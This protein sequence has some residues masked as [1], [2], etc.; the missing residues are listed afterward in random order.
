[1]RLS[2]AKELFYKLSNEL[3]PDKTKTDTD[4]TFVEMKQEYDDLLAIE[5]RWTDI[6]EFTRIKYQ[7][8]EVIKEKPVIDP[9]GIAQVMDAFGL[10]I[11]LIKQG[12]KFMKKIN[13]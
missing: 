13:K 3:H 9:Q 11:D 12:R 7:Y 1:M 8:C 10:G 6:K 4:D 2:E 5:R